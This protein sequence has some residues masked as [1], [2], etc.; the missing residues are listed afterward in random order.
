[1]KFSIIIN[2]RKNVVL[3]AHTKMIERAYSVYWN[4]K[5]KILSVYAQTYDA[6]YLLRTSSEPTLIFYQRTLNYSS[7]LGT[8]M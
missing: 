6:K 5:Y 3:Y 2:T 8:Y 4:I 7:Q 1:M